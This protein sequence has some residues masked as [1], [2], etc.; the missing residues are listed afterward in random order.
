MAERLALILAGLLA[1]NVLP[2]Q[3]IAPAPTAAETAKPA[4]IGRAHV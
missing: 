4:E 1:V 3:T 2:A